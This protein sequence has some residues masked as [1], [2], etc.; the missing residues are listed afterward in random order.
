MSLVQTIYSQMT[1]LIRP[2]VLGKI[3]YISNLIHYGMLMYMFFDGL[4][5][6]AYSSVLYIIR[7]KKKPSF[8]ES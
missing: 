6:L 5:V 4:T 1:E 2:A 7:H 3:L 8:G